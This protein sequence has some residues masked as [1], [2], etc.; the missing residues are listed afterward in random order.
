MTDDVLPAG[1]R[2]LAVEPADWQIVGTLK[3]SQACGFMRRKDDPPFKAL[4]DGVLTQLMKA[5]S[6]R[7]TTR[8]SRSRRRRRSCRSTAR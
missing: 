3:S 8:G 7:C 2:P 5:R 6:T 4:V 1:V